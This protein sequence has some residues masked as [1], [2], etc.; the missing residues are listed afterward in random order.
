MCLIFVLVSIKMKYKQIKLKN[1]VM[2]T[3]LLM[4]P[5]AL[6][7]ASWPSAVVGMLP[8]HSEWASVLSKESAERCMAVASNFG[9]GGSDRR[10]WLPIFCLAACGSANSSSC[11]S[12]NT[13]LI[14]TARWPQISGRSE[15]PISPAEFTFSCFAWNRERHNM[16]LWQLNCGILLCFL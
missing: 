16:S 14:T 8:F 5:A 1:V 10:F 9:T 11:S 13:S 3:D 6:P 2:V 7:S 12:W 4:S 15:L